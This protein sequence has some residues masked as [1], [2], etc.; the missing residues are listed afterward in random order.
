MKLNRGKQ[1]VL[2]I[3]IKAEGKK[4]LDLSFLRVFDEIKRSFTMDRL[5]D[6]LQHHFL[7]PQQQHLEID[8]S[9]TLDRSID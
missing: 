2:S 7:K 3:H 1:T 8:W 4:D 5:V 6:P 9:I